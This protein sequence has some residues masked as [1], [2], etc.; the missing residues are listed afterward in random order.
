MIPDEITK[1]VDEGKI[2]LPMLEAVDIAEAVLY[3]LRTP[4]R[5]QVVIIIIRNGNEVFLHN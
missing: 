2:S 1:A 5:V 3:A 4:P